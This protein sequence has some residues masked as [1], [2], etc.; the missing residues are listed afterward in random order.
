MI[1]YRCEVSV[2]KIEDS[3]QKPGVLCLVWIL[4]IAGIA[5]TLSSCEKPE[6]ERMK[7]RFEESRQSEEEYL[8]LERIEQF[9]N[10]GLLNN[11][12][13][14]LQPPLYPPSELPTP[15]ANLPSLDEF[16]QRQERKQ[17][18][19]QLDRIERKQREQELQELARSSR[20]SLLKGLEDQ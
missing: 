15:Q 1:I 16:Q 14:N 3:C 19:D 11:T 7:D 9:S 18:K 8:A 20:E 4:I 6:N 13:S 10:K 5:M 17:I 2:V 12:R